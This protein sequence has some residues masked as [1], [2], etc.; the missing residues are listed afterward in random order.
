MISE[1]GESGPVRSTYLT[2][3]PVDD[4]GENRR[5]G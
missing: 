4:G 3:C 5:T 1:R 2:D